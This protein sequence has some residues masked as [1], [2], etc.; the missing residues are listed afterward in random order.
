MPGRWSFKRIII[1]FSIA[2]FCLGLF[3]LNRGTKEEYLKVPLSDFLTE[4]SNKRIVNIKVYPNSAYAIGEYLGKGPKVQVLTHL[5]P[6]QSFFVKQLLEYDARV[7][8]VNNDG[9]TFWL[10]FLVNW[11]PNLLLFGLIF[12]SNLG[13]FSFGRSKT[14]KADHLKRVTFDDVAGLPEAKEELKEIVDFLKN[15]LEF[16]RVG[17]KIPR[18][19][20]L[21]GPPG[22]GKTLLARAIAGE[23][24]VPFMYTSGSEFTEMFVGIGA[25]RVRNLF[26][27]AR[28]NAPCI[29]YIDEVDS[30]AKRRDMRF[31]QNDEREGTLNQLLVELDG[32]SKSEGVIVIMSTN[33]SDVLDPAL[34]RPGRVDRQIKIGL[35]YAT[36]RFEIL[37]THLKSTEVDPKGIDL[38]TVVHITSGC[39]GADLANIVNEAAISVGR[40]KGKF[41]DKATLENAMSKALLGSSIKLNIKDAELDLTAHH[42]A[43]HVIASVFTENS[44]PIF[45][46]TIMPTE[47]ALGMVVPVPA[48]ESFSYSKAQALDRLCVLMAGRLGEEMHVG[49]D[50]VTAGASN[51]FEKATS[52]AYK[53]VA[54]WGMDEE[55]GPLNIS[56]SEISQELSYKI[57]MQVMQI[58]KT[59]V[60][61]TRAL[62]DEHRE[63]KN[64]IAKAL[65]ENEVLDHDQIM[66]I[67]GKQSTL[68]IS[69]DPDLYV[70]IP[71]K[72]TRHK[73]DKPEK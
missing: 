65:R 64:N 67:I 26:G 22:T 48:D 54:E 19:V 73:E 4:V 3:F 11:L 72:Q 44:E 40:N 37:K 21:Y 31:S 43:A 29:I 20:L 42:E 33:R 5:Q 6:K 30:L 57:D 28:K 66:T 16:T 32:F 69:D 18:G 12:Y 58:L 9:N 41:I 68:K 38:K 1:S 60:T 36:G 62:L 61:R 2:L 71:N 46:A 34:L 63:V 24:N 55:I 25:S 47:V 8:I 27:T 13:R 14:K 23:A 52:V 17:A 35:P 70:Y 45:K 50:K 53:M 39:S 49:P 7:D 51:D 59:C 10:A 15:P 56:R